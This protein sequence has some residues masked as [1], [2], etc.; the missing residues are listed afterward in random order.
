MTAYPPMLVALVHCARC[1]SLTCAALHACSGREARYLTASSRVLS[2][3]SARG[4]GQDAD[5]VAPRRNTHKPRRRA[6]HV[7]GQA[8]LDRSPAD[9]F[10]EEGF[11]CDMHIARLHRLPAAFE[12]SDDRLLDPVVPAMP[13]RNSGLRSLDVAALRPAVVVIELV[14]RSKNPVQQGFQGSRGVGMVS[15]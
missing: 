13:V 5:R 9:G 15:G 11:S 2:S 8:R 4:S 6:G 1:D 3:R 7:G 10:T 14:E 12:H